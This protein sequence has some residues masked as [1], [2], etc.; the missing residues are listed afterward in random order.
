MDGFPPPTDWIGRSLAMLDGEEV[1]SV[2]YVAGLEAQARDMIAALALVQSRN[3]SLRDKFSTD[4]DS[5][6]RTVGWSQYDRTITNPTLTETLNGW[7]ISVAD[8]AA[9]AIRNAESP[10]KH[11]QVVSDVHRAVE[12]IMRDRGERPERL[13]ASA[14]GNALSYLRR[15][16]EIRRAE[17]GYSATRK[18]RPAAPQMSGPKDRERSRESD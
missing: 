18:L 4:W 11:Y 10:M 5:V 12:A 15:R 6:D 17:A 7:G 9:D 8:L 3:M 16:G 1:I 13:S 14:V 2:A